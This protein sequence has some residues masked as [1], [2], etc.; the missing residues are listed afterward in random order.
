LQRIAIGIVAVCRRAGRACEYAPHRADL[1]GP[2]VEGLRRRARNELALI[3]VRPRRRIAA[4]ARLAQP[5]AAPD[6]GGRNRA[7]AAGRRA[8]DRGAAAETV[9][10]EGGLLAGLRR[11][12]DADEAVLGVPGVGALPVR[13]QIAVEVV[14]ERLAGEPRRCLGDY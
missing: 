10:G 13:E 1:V 9:I 2:V 6:I 4:S 8:R 3:V 5:L 14:G 7:A 11:I 12:G